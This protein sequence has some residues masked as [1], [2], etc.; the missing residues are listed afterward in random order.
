M[1]APRWLCRLT[2]RH[3]AQPRGDHDRDDHREHDRAAAPEQHRCRQHADRVGA[4]RRRCRPSEN[5]EVTTRA[6]SRAGAIIATTRRKAGCGVPAP[7]HDRAG[8]LDHRVVTARPEDR[9]PDRRH[10]RSPR[11]AAAAAAR[12]GTPGG[13]NGTSASAIAAP[14][15]CHARASGARAARRSGCRGRTS[16]TPRRGRAGRCLPAGRRRSAPTTVPRIQVTYC[17]TVRAEQQ[18]PVEGAVAAVGQRPRRVDHR[19]ALDRPLERTT[20]E[21]RREG[22]A[23]REEPAVHQRPGRDRRPR[24]C[25]RWPGPRAPAN[26]ADPAK[27]IA[28][29][30]IA[31]SGENPA[32]RARTPK[33]IDKHEPHRRRTGCRAGSRPAKDGVHRR[34]ARARHRPGIRRLL[35]AFVET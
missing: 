3:G 13:V 20:R 10:R 21:R 31:W 7:E 28:A 9:P 30:R 29:V 6:A 16:G 27:T 4:D 22:G 17:G 2:V 8:R 25:L 32:C 12:I 33:D 35:R 19:L 18:P 34:H 5:A 14:Q 1:A 11:S 24:R 23:H 26:C 15:Q